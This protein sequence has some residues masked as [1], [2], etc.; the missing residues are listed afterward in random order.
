MSDI[1]SLH[2]TM[3]L[4]DTVVAGARDIRLLELLFLEAILSPKSVSDKIIS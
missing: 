3:L 1:S 4:L 2:S